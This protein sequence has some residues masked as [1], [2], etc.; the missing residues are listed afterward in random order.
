MLD[1]KLEQLIAPELE[2]LGF[3]CVKLEIVGS[4]NSPVVRLYIDKPGGVGIDDCSLVSRTVGLLLEKDDPF[5]GRY[6]LEVSSPGSNR[7]LV[8]ESHFQQFEGEMAK[9]QVFTK[10]GKLTYTGLIRSCINGVLT[11]D[12]EDEEAVEID[13]PYILKA[14]L[15]GQD[16]KI[17]K[18]TKTSKREKRAGRARSDGHSA[19]AERGRKRKGDQK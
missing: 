18:K 12:T 10:P 13:L 14:S 7:P 8:K 11:L 19:P 3:E 9:V 1:S 5:P 17:D 6:L 4:S 2:A 16:Y 15:I